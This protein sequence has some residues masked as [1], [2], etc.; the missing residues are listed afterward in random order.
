LLEDLDKK[1]IQMV[2]K[3]ANRKPDCKGIG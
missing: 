3:W 1:I 2:E